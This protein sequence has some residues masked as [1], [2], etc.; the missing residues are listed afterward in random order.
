MVYVRVAT[1]ALN[2]WALDFDGNSDRIIASIVE[3]KAQGA[4]YRLGPELEISAYGCEDHF[5]EIDT[6]NH[7][8]ES[9]AG[10]LKGDATNG[11]LCDIGM[12]V[13]H[14]TVSFWRTFAPLTD[15]GTLGSL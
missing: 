14:N 11:I 9:L 4:K 15:M 8:A 3:A 13:L 10:I 7:S 12:A 5:H 2:Q 1:C 6:F